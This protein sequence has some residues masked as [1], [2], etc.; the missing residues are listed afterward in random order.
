MYV[1]VHTVLSQSC[2]WS[3]A[4]N[5]ANAVQKTTREDSKEQVTP[6]CVYTMMREAC[7]LSAALTADE[8]MD[9]SFDM[10]G[11]ALRYP[12]VAVLPNRGVLPP[13]C[14]LEP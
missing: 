6:V 2:I 13:R 4:P 14:P 7:T 11:L 8:A 12:R 3:A 9:S 10:T 5:N 1:C